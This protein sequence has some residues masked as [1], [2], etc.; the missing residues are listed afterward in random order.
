MLHGFAVFQGRGASVLDLKVDRDNPA[1]RF[2]D[3][4]GMRPVEG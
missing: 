3:S 4:L 2:Y 1:L